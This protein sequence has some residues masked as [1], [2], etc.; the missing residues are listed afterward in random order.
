MPMVSFALWPN[1]EIPGA[2]VFL[3]LGLILVFSTI[4][5]AAVRTRPM[6]AKT[7]DEE[8]IWLQG[9]PTEYVAAFSQ[10]AAEA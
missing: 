9:V 6:R 3:I 1:L 5:Y 4:V 2:F 8:F 7:I 10:A